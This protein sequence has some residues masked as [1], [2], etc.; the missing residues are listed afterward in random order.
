MTLPAGRGP[1]GLPLGIQ[2]VGRRGR[3]EQLFDAAA[4]VEAHL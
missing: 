3:D 1:E 4:W 2:L